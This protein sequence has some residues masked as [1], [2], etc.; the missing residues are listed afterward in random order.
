MVYR[1]VKNYNLKKGDVIFVRSSVKPTGVGLTTLINDHF[2]NVVYSGFLIRFRTGSTI[3]ADKFKVHC[4]YADYF[5][6]KLISKSTISANTNINQVALGSLPL[7][8]PPLPEQQKIAEILST[9]DRAIANVQLIINNL[10]LRNK[11]LAFSLLTGK[12]R[13]KGFEDNPAKILEIRDVAKEISIKNKED[14]NFTVFSCTKYN[15]L[16]PSLEYFGKK[17]YSDNLKT[18]KVIK[19]NQFAYATNHIEE[20]SI[21]ILEREEIGLISPM[22]TIFEFNENVNIDYI[23]KILKSDFYINEYKRKMEGSIDRRGGLR[24]NAFA[25]IKINLPSLE[26]QTAIAEILN[27]AQQELKQYQEKLKALELQKK[28]LMQQLLTG[29]IRT[30]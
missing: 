21:G 12:K 10:Q 13:V 6:N 18:Y 19:R 2:P 7:I 5:R 1:G 3:L 17:I 8:I 14:N 15:G 24:W 20:G 26:E 27:T 30:V 11:A 9:W 4:F 22:Y 28:G 25:Q 29:K 16:V 23:F